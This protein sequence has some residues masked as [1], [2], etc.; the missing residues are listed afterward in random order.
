MNWA[1]LVALALPPVCLLV[2]WILGRREERT[3]QRQWA[4]W[5]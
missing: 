5:N 1:D 2:G 3:T 4:R